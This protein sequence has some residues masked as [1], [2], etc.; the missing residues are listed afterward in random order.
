MVGDIGSWFD[1]LN[2]GAVGGVVAILGL[3]GGLA[4]W[5]VNVIR[6]EVRDRVVTPDSV[7]GTIGE[8]VAAIAVT[9]ERHTGEDNERFAHV[10]AEIGKPEPPYGEAAKKANGKHPKKGKGKSRPKV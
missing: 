2:W 4:R 9:D 1:N 7:P 3:L 6:H 5:I 8:T 10:W